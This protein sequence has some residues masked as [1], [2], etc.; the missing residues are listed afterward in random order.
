M[1]ELGFDSVWVH[2]GYFDIIHQARR[3]SFGAGGRGGGMG[4][5]GRERG[6]GGEGAEEG[7]WYQS[8]GEE[9][10]KAALAV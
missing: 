9:R 3:E 10:E 7:G 5:G 6:R 1:H 2:S 8:R 4:E